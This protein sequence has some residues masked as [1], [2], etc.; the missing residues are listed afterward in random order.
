MVLYVGCILFVVDNDK[1]I[2]NG[3]SKISTENNR[4]VE[5]VCET[6]HVDTEVKW[7][8]WTQEMRN[9]IRCFPKQYGYSHRILIHEYQPSDEGTIVV[10]AGSEHFSARISGK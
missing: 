5:I 7:F 3:P 6:K 8:I 9:I 10:V 1:E 4:N 2:I